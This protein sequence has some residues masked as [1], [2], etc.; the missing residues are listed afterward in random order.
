M[1]PLGYANHGRLEVFLNDEWGTVCDDYFG[2]YDAD[3]V[4]RQLGFSGPSSSN[5]V[6]GTCSGCSTPIGA[7]SIQ[8][9]GMQWFG[10][11]LLCPC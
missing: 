3:T 5:L 1:N 8:G 4:C 9:L 6:L 10:I 11:V 7:Y 2:S